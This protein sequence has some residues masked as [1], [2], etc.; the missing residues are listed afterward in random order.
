MCARVRACVL[1]SVLVHHSMSS[2]PDLLFTLA[3]QFMRDQRCL[4]SSS[5]TEQML[6]RISLAQSEKENSCIKDENC[7]ECKPDSKQIRPAC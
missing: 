7:E 6:K 4:L 3:L 1:A 2:I 5:T